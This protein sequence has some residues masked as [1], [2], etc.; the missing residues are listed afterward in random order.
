MKEHMD[1]IW[2]KVA[3]KQSLETAARA[4]LVRQDGVWAL[5]LSISAACGLLMALLPV[6]GAAQA[7]AGII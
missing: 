2:A 5:K 3:E 7:F 6:A 1:A 4:L